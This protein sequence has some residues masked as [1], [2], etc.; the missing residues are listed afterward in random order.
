[1]ATPG[2]F[3]ARIQRRKNVLLGLCVSWRSVE[4]SSCL[5]LCRRETSCGVRTLA[6]DDLR[7]EMAPRWVFNEPVFHPIDLRIASVESRLVYSRILCRRN[8]AG[9]GLVC[10]LPTPHLGEVVKRF[11]ISET[12]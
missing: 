3:A 12:R 10:G 4:R 11:V 6:L 7:I 9:F 5:Y 8:I 2:K 1:N